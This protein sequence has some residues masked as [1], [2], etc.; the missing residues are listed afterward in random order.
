LQDLQ[1]GALGRAGKRE[2]P[3]WVSMQKWCVGS[4][5]AYVTALFETDETELTIEHKAKYLTGCEQSGYVEVYN[6]PIQIVYTIMG[7]LR[8]YR[9]PNGHYFYYGGSYTEGWVIEV[10]IWGPYNTGRVVEAFKV[11]CSYECNGIACPIY[12]NWVCNDNFALI[13]RR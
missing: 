1:S 3:L 5:D 8:V 4:P 12:E 13:W 11:S 10:E 6:D 2:L 9:S 7:V